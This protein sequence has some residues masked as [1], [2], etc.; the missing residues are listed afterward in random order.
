MHEAAVDVGAVGARRIMC[1][2]LGARGWL[3]WDR[4]SLIEGETGPCEWLGCMQTAVDGIIES[5]EMSVCRNGN[6]LGR[7]QE[8]VDDGCN[9]KEQHLGPFTTG[10]L[11]IQSPFS[12]SFGFLVCDTPGSYIWAV[13]VTYLTILLGLTSDS[14]SFVP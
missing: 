7:I 1:L 6:G 9:V 2:D 5:I 12:D 13:L 11:R 3:D 10:C 14:T 8:E 4:L